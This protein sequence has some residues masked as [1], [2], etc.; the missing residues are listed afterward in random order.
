MTFTRIAALALLTAVSATA[1]T[2]CSIGDTLNNER[3]TEF[4]TSAELVDTWSKSA[5]WLPTDATDIITRETPDA[6]PAVLLATSATALDPDLCVEIERQS[7]PVF[8]VDGAPK[9]YVD[10]VFACGD[11][12]VIPT[13]DG[14]YG[15]TPNH[16]DEKAASARLTG[17]ARA[18]PRPANSER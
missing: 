17:C 8:S 4:S 9:A 7:G 3:V 6:E 10:T 16:P 11:W 18:P 1:L 2:G 12:A 13:D 5:P 15:W 14:W